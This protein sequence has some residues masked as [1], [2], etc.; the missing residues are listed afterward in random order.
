MPKTVVVLGAR[1]LGGAIVDHC[2]E[3]GWNA[4]AVARSEDTL[5]R[6]R[7]RGA[8]AIEADASD[9]D[10]LTEAL[11]DARR[12]FGSVDAVVNAVTASRPPSTGPF[13][14]GPLDAADLEAFRGWT[15]AVAEQAF[16]FL[17]TGIVALRQSGGGTLVQITGGSSRRAMPGRGLWAAGAFATRAL[18]QAAA[19][20]L[21][22]QGIHVALLAVDATI[23]SPKTEAYTRDLAR[24]AL[25]DMPSVARAVGFLIEQ[26]PRG[27]THDL[28]ITPAGDRWVP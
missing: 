1:N 27:M 18:V 4:A 25:A 26:G 10:A 19:Q 11:A 20:E 6:V 12:Q 15:V 24:E 14:G 7:E 5:A 3:Q 13:G 22:A 9:A 2:V 17:S 28:V 8:M 21:R 23:E 16:V